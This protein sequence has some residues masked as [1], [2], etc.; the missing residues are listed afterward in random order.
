[1]LELMIYRRKRRRLGGKSG[2][3]RFE[4]DKRH[5]ISGFG[6]GDYVRLRDDFGKV[7]QGHV[8]DQGDNTLRMIFRDEDGNRISG[9]SDQNGVVLRDEKGNSWRG[10]ID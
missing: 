3:Y 6:D 9:I 8:E 1:M 7:W 5:H 4:S 10:F 2:F